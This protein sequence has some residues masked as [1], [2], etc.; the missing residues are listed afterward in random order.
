MTEMRKLWNL[1]RNWGDRSRQNILLL[2]SVSFQVL[3][4]VLRN[5]FGSCGGFCWKR[6]YNKRL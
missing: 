6:F 2:V 1:P 3:C 5:R 4:A